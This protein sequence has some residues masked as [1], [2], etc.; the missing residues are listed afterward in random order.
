MDQELCLWLEA[1]AVEQ[2]AIKGRVRT[3]L[4]QC[5]R[6]GVSARL[7]WTWC[8]HGKKDSTQRQE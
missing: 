7:K 5:W 4:D 1:E 8:C 6:Y 3:A 2:L